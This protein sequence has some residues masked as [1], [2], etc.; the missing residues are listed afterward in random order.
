M[1]VNMSD[2]T[3]SIKWAVDAF[4]DGRNV[5]YDRF[6]RYI[7]GDHP[8]A[9]ATPKYE[10]VFGRAY[11]AF[12]YNRCEMA[13]DAHTDR[14]RVQGFDSNDS[15]ISQAAIDLWDDNRMDQRDNGL[16][17]DAFGLGDGY[18]IAEKSASTDEVNM[19]VNSPQ[20]MRVHWNEEEPDKIDMAAKYW[21][22]GDDHGRLTIYKPGVVEKYITS[23][24]ATSGIP[25]SV[26]AFTR[27]EVEGE[28]WPVKLDVPDVVPVFHIANNGRANAYG[29]SELR[30]V[31]PLQ[32]ALNKTI[33][34]MM[35]AME[36]TAFPARVLMGVDAPR[37]PEEKAL[38]DAFE[39][40]LTRVWTMS[41][42]QAKIGE[43]SAT[44]IL[45][46][47]AVAE[48]FDKSVSRVT[49]IPIHWLGMSTEIESGRARQVAEAAFVAKMEDRQRSFGHAISEAV[50]YGLRLKSMDVA[51]GELK[52]EWAS[53]E[54]TTDQDELDKM[55]Q[56]Q[57]LGMAL[58]T[59]LRQEGYSPEDVEVIMQERR[60]QA[61][62]AMRQFS[63]G[64][65]EEV[66]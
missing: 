33:T 60:E 37:T 61:D 53:A 9:F 4:R 5:G 23:N 10:S 41:D 46:Y 38:V 47:I 3:D 21:K 12:A 54:S 31:L 66:V 40:G 14:M 2:V 11:G 65:E 15:A 55:L 64:Y 39:S 26:G 35:I 62:E 36:L 19:W 17:N 45:Q 16:F 42:P 27:R 18:L 1:G 6:Q 57:S 58:E 13:V 49:K 63:R 20:S 7:N 24:R 44:N 59:I 56:K 30:S 43:F 29:V 28:A 52:T 34:D 48:Y 50:S 8:L 22:G 32:D 51:P 25:N